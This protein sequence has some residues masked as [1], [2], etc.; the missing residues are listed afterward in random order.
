MTGQSTFFVELAE[1]AAMLHKAS[2]RSLVALDELGR[3]TATLDGAAIASAVRHSY[4]TTMSQAVTVPSHSCYSAIPARSQSAFPGAVGHSA[5]TALTLKSICQCS[6]HLA[7]GVRGLAAVAMLLLVSA[8]AHPSHCQCC[9]CCTTC[10]TILHLIC[11]KQWM[12]P[13]LHS[14]CCCH[15]MWP[16]P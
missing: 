16:P 7:T 4:V 11:Q 1:T 12:E 9:S 13:R 14:Y 3:G 2:S 6:I 8:E 10:C 15:T 5:S